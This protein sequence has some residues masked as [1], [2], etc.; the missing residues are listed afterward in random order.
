MPNDYKK[1]ICDAMLFNKIATDGNGII[2]LR[3]SKET[4]K[5]GDI[6][7]LCG[8]EGDEYQ[9]CYQLVQ[10]N[11]KLYNYDFTDENK[12]IIGINK[13]SDVISDVDG[14]YKV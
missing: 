11:Y 1:M 4:Y 6:L 9:N 12:Y 13:I 10:I 2:E 5:N 3:V 8:Y 7:M 14:L